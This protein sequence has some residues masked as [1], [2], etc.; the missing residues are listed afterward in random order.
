MVRALFAVAREMQPS[1][2]FVDEIDSL[3]SARSTGEHEASRRLKTEFLVQLDG[4]A[5]A[6]DERI[7]IMG[8]TNRPSE[9][10][11]AVIRRM[12]K[13][14]Y[15]PLPDSDAR[16]SLIQHLLIKQS[17]EL[18]ARQLKQVVDATEGYSGSVSTILST[19]NNQKY[20]CMA[21]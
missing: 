17:S 7:L 10:D 8:A 4:A 16:G 19:T 5:T 2:I 3:L 13:R 11:D 15:V 20:V 6:N 12:V 9:L 21:Y 18:T 14:V 1:V